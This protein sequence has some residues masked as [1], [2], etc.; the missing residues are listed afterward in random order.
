MEDRDGHGICKWL[1]L[2]IEDGDEN[3]QGYFLCL[4]SS[5][6]HIWEARRH[7]RSFSSLFKLTFL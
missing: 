2:I 5:P 1:F 3:E 4:V 7:N 6:R